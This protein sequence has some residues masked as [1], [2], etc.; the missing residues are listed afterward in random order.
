MLPCPA[1][2]VL[3]IEPVVS[4]ILGKCSAVYI[5]RTA[6]GTLKWLDGSDFEAI[7]S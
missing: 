2:G 4:C 1:Y 3:E 6:S 5:F 7:W